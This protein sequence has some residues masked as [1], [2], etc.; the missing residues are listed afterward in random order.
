M[1]IYDEDAERFYSPSIDEDDELMIYTFLPLYEP[2]WPCPRLRET[3]ERLGWE[4]LYIHEA[5]RGPDDSTSRRLHGSPRVGPNRPRATRGR[6]LHKDREGSPKAE[7]ASPGHT[8]L[9][10]LQ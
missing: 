8:R 6:P 7:R 2:P 3:I 4:P 9:R 10:R 1:P 5:T